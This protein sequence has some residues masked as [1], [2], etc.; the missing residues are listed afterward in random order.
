MRGDLEAVFESWIGQPAIMR[1]SV[2][3]VRLSLR[4]IVLK[5]KAETLLLR[6]DNGPDLEV[7]KNAVLAIEEARLHRN[8][9]QSV[10]IESAHDLTRITTKRQTPHAL[11]RISQPLLNLWPYTT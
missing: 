2:G 1:L 8:D 6:P 5:E 7:N 3:C 11:Q 4:G 10:A 9:R